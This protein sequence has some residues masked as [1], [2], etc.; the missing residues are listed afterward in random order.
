MTPDEHTNQEVMLDVG[1]G[2]IIY[3]Q[4]WGNKNA[5]K[6]IIYLHGGPG[7]GVSN[8]DRRRFDPLTQ[9]VI[10]F[11]Q[12]GS[13]K[14]TPLYSL[15]NNTTPQLVEDIEKI[16]T[17]LSLPKVIL[18]GGSWGSTLALAFAIAHPDRVEA[19]L[20]YG[21]FTASKD[22]IE[23]L[24][25]GGYIDFFPDVWQQYLA[26]TPTKHLNDPSAYHYTQALGADKV[27]AKKSAY[28]YEAMELALLKL[29]EK[30][31]PEDF[32]TY[33][34]GKITTEMHYGANNFFM[35][36]NHILDNVA[37]L[38]MPVW[39]VQGRYDMVCR[40]FA[41]Y[42]LNERLHNSR[43]IWTINGHINQHEAKNI[44]KLLLEQ[45]SKDS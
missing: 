42:R 45:L 36:D 24:S 6:P 28:A 15:E 9:R 41:A 10:F 25:S 21:V 5:S 23:W 40:P 26:A 13:G 18:N 38:T 8:R 1:D 32:E 22:E 7:N 39:L 17:S 14:S 33:D 29:D 35:D 27:A 19:I 43:L 16:I 11:D 4:D 37:K 20:I 31:I 12:R 3:V 2:H 30:Y 34:P 44:V